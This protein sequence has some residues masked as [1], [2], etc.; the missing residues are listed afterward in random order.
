MLIIHRVNGCPCGDSVIHLY[1]GADSTK[2][3][4]V[5]EKLL[6][7]LKGSNY[8][9]SALHNQEPTLYAHFQLIWSIRVDHMVT[10][11]PSYVFFLSVVTNRAVFICDARLAHPQAFQRGALVVLHSINYHY[12][13]LTPNV[14]GAALVQIA[15]AFV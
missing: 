12:P 8:R 6:V 3:Q 4:E 7:F 13:Y 14:S 10:D 15:K 5:R 2:Q 11:L 9:K 1:C